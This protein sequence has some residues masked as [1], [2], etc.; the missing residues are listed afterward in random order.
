MKEIE[1]FCLHIHITLTLDEN[2]FTLIK[3][4]CTYFTRNKKQSLL[5]RHKYDNG[6]SVNDLL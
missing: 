6:K 1:L 2:N 5:F 3:K 4:H